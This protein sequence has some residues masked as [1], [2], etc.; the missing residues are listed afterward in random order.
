MAI[1]KYAPKFVRVFKYTDPDT[2]ETDDIVFR[3]NGNLFPLF[4]SYTGVELGKALDDYKKGLTEM[5]SEDTIKAIAAFDSAKDADAKLETVMSSPDVFL[6]ML[7]AAN[8]T[9]TIDGGLSLVELI[10]IVMHVCALPEDEHAEALAAGYELL[11]QDCYEDP[12]LALD[13]LLLAIQY[14]EH[15]KKKTPCFGA[16]DRQP[17]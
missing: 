12:Q 17:D 7:Q 15:A 8:D 2:G 5:L 6:K 10:L 14:E 13:L 3:A 16:K 4:K 11:P 1:K 9:A